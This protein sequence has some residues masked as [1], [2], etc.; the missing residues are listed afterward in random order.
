MQILPYI[1]KTVRTL[2]PGKAVE[3]LDHSDITLG[4]LGGAATLENLA[5]SYRTQ[6]AVTHK[7]AVALLA[8]L[9][10]KLKFVCTET[11]M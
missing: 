5:G 8:I 9:P 11:C 10:G 3:P 1:H 6:H 7:P 2:S 4:I